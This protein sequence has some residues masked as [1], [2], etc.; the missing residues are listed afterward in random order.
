M[1]SDEITT[2]VPSACFAPRGGIVRALGDA[3]VVRLLGSV[4]NPTAGRLRVTLPSGRNATFGSANGDTAAHVVLRNYRVLSRTLRRGTLGFA[5]SYM[6]GDLDTDDLIGL[7]NY[8]MDNEAALAAA[9]PRLVRSGRSDRVFHRRRPNT[10][11]G[12]RR[13]IAAHY[14]LGNTFYG[15]WLDAGLTYSSGL[16]ATPDVTLEAA[17][18]AKNDRILA[19]LDVSQTH[20]ILEIGCGWGGFVEAAAERAGSVTGITISR[21]QFE[22]ATTRIA[23]TR[24]AS[25][26]HIRLEDYR[27]TTGSFDRI[28]SIEMIEAVGEENWPLYFRKIAD[29][30]KPGGKAVI[31]AITIREDVFDAYR[32]NPDFIQRYIFPGGMLPTLQAMR[33]HAEA[34]GL[35]FETLELFGGSYALTLAE[36]RQ[37][38][39][40]A[41]PRIAALGFDERFRRM[42]GYYLSYC[43]VGFERGT[44]D[45]GLYRLRKPD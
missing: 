26:A 28:A 15:L 41:W 17:Q 20:S 35:G 38:F 7:F 1:A 43:Q 3:A 34:A 14:D 9:L 11:S 13:N 30:L 18:H 22:A 44:I 37:R 12:S 16:Y 40:R 33:Q 27:D 36:W 4:L 19:A 8:F 45:V 23:R 29:R 31:Q 39:G 21:Q 2:A 10:P 24:Y 25:R 32:A 42:W 5:D 6:A